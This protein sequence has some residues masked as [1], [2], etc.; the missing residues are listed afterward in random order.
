MLLLI[1][2]CSL[3]SLFICYIGYLIWKK[4]KLHLIAGYDENSFYGNHEKLA[5][6]VGIFSFFI[7]IKTFLLPFGVHLFGPS[8]GLGYILLVVAAS[9]GLVIKVNTKSST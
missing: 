8:A 6:T 2:I 1:I 4:K 3:I 5:K 9:I 7:G